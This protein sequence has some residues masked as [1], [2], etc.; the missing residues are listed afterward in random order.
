VVLLEKERQAG[1]HSSGRNAAMVRQVTPDEAVSE[2]AR[3][4]ARAI[5]ELARQLARADRADL[6][7]RGGS[8]LVASGER[9]GALDADAQRAA[10]AGLAVERWNRGQAARRVP[11]LAG[12]PFEAGCFCPADGVVDVAALLRWYLDAARAAGARVLLS[13]D[14]DEIVSAGGEVREVRAGALR[15]RTPAVVN[16]AGGWAGSLGELAGASPVP[17]RPTRRHLFVSGPEARLSAEWPFVWDL[18][19]ELYFRPE[20]GGLLLSACDVGEPGPSLESD[21]VRQEVLELLARKVSRR[22]PALAEITIRRGW[23]G[24]RTLTPDGR[25]VIG[26]DPRLGGFFWVAGLGG[27]GVTTSAAVGELA[28]ELVLDP[29]RDAANPHTPS[30]FAEK[31]DMLHLHSV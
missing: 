21:A 20:S 1:F 28:A 17:L 24:I 16:A 27:H 11:A 13:T 25:F 9:I 6:L 4:G 7:R 30:R 22:F 14:V 31:G 5:D 3:A 2:L 23:S 15:I 29:A 12:A 19:E 10:A 8:L 26:P 18:S